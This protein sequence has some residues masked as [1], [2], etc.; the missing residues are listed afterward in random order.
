MDYFAVSCEV[1]ADLISSSGVQ[2]KTLRLTAKQN[3]F[4]MTFVITAW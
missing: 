4:V 1:D 3:M 2:I